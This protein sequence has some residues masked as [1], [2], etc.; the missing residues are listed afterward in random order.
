M[1]RRKER[2][3][4]KNLFY[5]IIGI[6][7]LVVSIVFEGI[8]L[9]IDLL[10]TKYIVIISIGLILFVALTVFLLNLK[11]LKRKIKKILSVISIIVVILMLIASFYICRTL[12]VL[13]NNGD[14][15]YKLEHYSVIVLKNS[16][17]ENIKDIKSRNVGY[18]KNS[19]GASEAKKSLSKKVNVEYDAYESTDLLMDDLMNSKIEV[20]II[21][22]SIKQILKEESKQFKKLTKTIYTFTVKIEVESTLKD[23]NV[24]KQPFAVY[25]SGIDTYGEVSSVS[26][27]DVNMVAVINPKTNQILLIS[28]PRDYYVQ[29][30]GTTGTKDKLTHAGIYGIDMSIQTIE[31][32]L[33]TEINYYFKVNFTSVIDIVNA[34]GGLDVYSE[35][36][37]V[38]YSGYSFKKG[39]NSV[40]G[41][42]ALDFV[43][44]RK[45][46]VDGDRQRG[47]NQQAL[48]EA[49]V[50]KATDK[51]IITKYNSLLNA[52]DGK[53]Q[54]NM[55]IKKL[56]SLI[57]M[58]LETMKPWNITSHSLTGTDSNNYTYTYYQL[59]YVMEPDQESINTAIKMIDDVIAGEVLDSSY[60]EVSGESNKV[61]QVSTKKNNKET[62]STKKEDNKKNSETQKEIM[63]NK[64]DNIKDGETIYT[65]TFNSDN[66]T[67]IKTQTIQSGEKVNIP[68]TPKKEG[69]EFIGWFV[70][71]QKYNFDEAV[72]QN[73]N[74]VAKWEQKITEEDTPITDNDNTDNNSN[75]IENNN[76][77][78]SSDTES[79]DL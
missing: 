24:T 43:R 72:N 52:I 36:S 23:V 22:D 34:L 20:I 13:M 73:I 1:K 37:F 50:R 68:S 41:K 26:R 48:I 25:I 19:I 49:M 33:E 61:I 65:I 69:Y 58:Q 4:I 18:F 63:D 2:K 54:T 8:L 39:L 76:S 51:S 3:K 67:D 30:H 17:Y 10:P 7:L 70:G 16:E 28:I 62:Q 77:E 6:L 35:Y 59:L 55:S 53:Y 31:D 9:Y 27:S 11:K 75:N 47:K 79:E 29:L 5:K 46:F 56:T 45:A 32:L 42:Q 71:N 74:L 66:G 78:V 60:N 12:G 40:D 38:S 21:E 15:K 14:S 64:E 57:K 44:T